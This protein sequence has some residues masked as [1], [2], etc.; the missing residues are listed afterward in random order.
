MTT[1]RG[2]EPFQR[3]DVAKA[4]EM[5]DSGEAHLIDVR[6]PKEWKEGHLEGATLIPVNSVL[7]RA[8]EL[9]T[10]GKPIVFYC[11]AGARSALAAEYAAALGHTN[12][13]NMEGGM[14]DWQAKKL[15]WV[16]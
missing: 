11:K 3:I 16:K 2:K 4:K 9:P 5:I 1:R 8:G 10:D 12:L 14:D 15:P 7:A 6:E 13:Y